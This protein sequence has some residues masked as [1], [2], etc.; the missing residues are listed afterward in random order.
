VA[1]DNLSREEQESHRE[2]L[3]AYQSLHKSLGWELL[4]ELAQEQIA[5]RHAMIMALEEKGLED[6]FEGIRLKAECRAL[7]LFVSLPETIIEQL[8]EDL[9]YVEEMGSE[10]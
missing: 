10:E 5:M 7:K 1:E 8:R 3:S 9:G 2:T 6:I 4:V